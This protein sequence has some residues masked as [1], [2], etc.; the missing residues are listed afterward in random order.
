MEI[1]FPADRKG[2]R[3]EGPHNAAAFPPC[4]LP[5]KLIVIVWTTSFCKEGDKVERR[6]IRMDGDTSS[7]IRSFRRRSD[8]RVGVYDPREQPGVNAPHAL[9]RIALLQINCRRI[10]SRVFS[11]RRPR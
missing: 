7:A 11:I 1:A 2:E 9:L 3:T 4:H 6:D 5:F 8:A 10:T